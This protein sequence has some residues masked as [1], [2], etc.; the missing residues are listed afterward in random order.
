MQRGFEDE[1]AFANES[2]ITVKVGEAIFMVSE[3]AIRASSE[4]VDATMK[5]PRQSKERTI[6]LPECDRG[7]FGIYHRWLL[8]GVIHNRQRADDQLS[9]LQLELLKLPRLF[10]LSQYLLDTDF[11][12]AL[13]DSLLQCTSALESKKSQF[14][15]SYGSKYYQNVPDGSPIRQLVADL[16]AW[17]MGKRQLQFIVGRKDKM[18]PDL[19]MNILQTV[20]ET[21]ISR[22]SGKSPL[23]RWE[24]S[25]KYH[26]HGNEKT[27]YRKK[28]ETP[29]TIP[30]KRP[31]SNEAQSPDAKRQASGQYEFCVEDSSMGTKVITVRVGREPNHTDFTVHEDPIR[32][33]SA[34]FQTA[35][36]HEWLESQERV[37]RLPECDATAFQIYTHWLY[38]GLLCAIPSG[39]SSSNGVSSSLVSGYLLGDYLQDG[40]YRDT[41]MDALIEWN[42]TTDAAQRASFLTSWTNTVYDKTREGNPL[43]KL[44]VDITVWDAPH[45][46]WASVIAKMPAS[47]VQD[48]CL[49]LSARYKAAGAKNPLR[50]GIS[51]CVYHSHGHKPCGVTEKAK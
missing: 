28:A 16:I 27:C 37:V 13:S 34:F 29:R 8:T 41:I 9:A 43:Q 14:P 36:R 21:Y 20:G 44:L 50:P 48:V 18:D 31:A 11:Q 26:C 17:T 25:C 51:S 3:H 33:S 5:G 38:S 2:M 47:H 19:A 1:V 6:S 24:N 7:A 23:H 15:P 42:R 10:K 49:C 4:F 45:N 35:F 39:A 32:A 40:N 12:D 22:G 46:W 30:T